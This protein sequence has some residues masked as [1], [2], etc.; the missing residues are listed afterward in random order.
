MCLSVSVGVRSSLRK[1]WE[2]SVWGCSLYARCWA[3]SDY[4]S[5]GL[6]VEK[7]IRTWSWEEQ[8]QTALFTDQLEPMRT[9]WNP[10]WW[11]PPL[12]STMWVN[13]RGSRG[14]HHGSTHT[15]SGGGP[16]EVRRGY[17]AGDGVAEAR[18]VPSQQGELQISEGTCKLQPW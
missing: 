18:L 2:W 9:K 10:L 8:G 15:S 13:C 16:G 12:I 4:S 11:L 6:A 14:L 7:E 3:W 5:A 17:L 1:L